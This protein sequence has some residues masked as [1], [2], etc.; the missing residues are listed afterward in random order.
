[1]TRGTMAGMTYYVD[2]PLRWGDMDAYGHV[3][4]VTYLQY[5]EEA[6]IGA[7]TQWFGDSDPVASGCVVARS[8]IEYLR[9][10]EHRAEP[11]RIELWVSDIK[12]ASFDV[13]YV[14]RDPD[15]VGAVVYAKATSTLVMY[16]LPTGT[17]R[18]I[19]PGQRAA[20]A[21]QSGEPVDL[22]SRR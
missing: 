3:N 7:F 15:G 16:D 14:L 12:G 13:D 1:M 6:R 22:R 20:L 21:A 9:P 11:L 18:R 19:T 5:L 8:E 4:N 17:P 2:V 10:L